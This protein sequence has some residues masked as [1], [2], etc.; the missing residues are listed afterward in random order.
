M[1]DQLNIIVEAL[2]GT[3]DGAFVVDEKLQIQVLNDSAKEILGYRKQDIKGL[4]CYQ[5]L[6]GLNEEDQ[7]IC[8]EN[9]QILNL[10][11]KSIPVTSYDVQVQTRYGKKYWV[12]MSIIPFR[13]NQKNGKKMLI[14]LFRDISQK[15]NDEI[16]FRRFIETS[17]RYLD[18]HYQPE[19][20]AEPHT[21][22]LV[23][24]LTPR[25]TEVLILLARG[26][27]TDEIAARLSVSSFTVRNHIQN[28]LEKLNAHSR[29]EAVAYALNHGLQL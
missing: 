14:H 29:L 8:R 20:E 13:P 25:Q 17:Q 4:Y 22:N 5:I 15:K 18:I 3:A 2:E 12:N 6:H 11:K 27:G 28:I 26:L 23:E 10:A 24:T 19:P 1:N 21:H 7:R 9:C 16:L